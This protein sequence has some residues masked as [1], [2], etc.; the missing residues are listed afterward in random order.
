M[1]IRFCI[2]SLVLLGAVSNAAMAISGNEQV[3]LA[4]SGR[5]EE[6]W[7]RI[8]QDIKPDAMKVGDLHALCF[9]YSKTKRYNKLLP[10]LEQLEIK[11]QKGSKR[12]RLFGLD[13]ATPTVY[14]MR[15]EALLELGQYAQAIV[16]AD[17]ALAWFKREKSDDKDIEI[18]AYSI[19]AIA[20]VLRSDRAAA[21]KYAAQL[22]QV[23]T[24][25]PLYS[26]FKSIKAIAIARTGLALGRWQRTYDAISSDKTFELHAFLDKLVSGAFL[27]GRNNW[28][29]QELPRAFMLNK[30]LFGLGRLAEAKIGYE[31]LIKTP[32]VKENGEIYW[33]LLYDRGQIAEAESKPDEAIPFYQRAIEVIE[34]Q[35]STIHTEASKIGFV[36]DKQQ[37]Y[38]RIVHALFQ[39][40]KQAE[41]LE[42]IERSKSRALVDLLAAKQ[43]FVLPKAAGNRAAQLLKEYEL[44]EAE[45][46]AQ[47]PVSAT[48]GKSQQRNLAVQAVRQIGTVAPELSTL[49]SVTSLP[50]QELQSL[51]PQD[52]ALIQ[53][54]YHG[55]EFY[56]FILTRTSLQT[57]MLELS[58]LE[59]DVRRFREAIDRREDQALV[60]A[61]SL[62]RRLI[63]PIATG[64][65]HKNLL[66]IPHGVLHYLPFSALHD[67]TNYLIDR[68]APRVLP[69]ASVLKYL[70]APSGAKLDSILVFGNPDLGDSRLDLPNAQLEAE[71]VA[72]RAAQSKLLL[73]KQASETAFRLLSSE[74]PYIHFASHGQFDPAAPLNSALLL[75]KDDSNDGMLT[76]NELYSIPLDADLVTLSACETGLGK[77]S[78]GDDVV[79]L[80]RGFLYAGASSVIA[81]LWQVDDAAT[82]QLMTRFYANLQ[83]A[84]KREALRDALLET[85]KKFPHP[86]F[87]AAFYLTGNAH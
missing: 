55:K 23:D 48:E 66:I 35:R 81:S 78:N 7:Q 64:L 26:D 69:S 24:S 15:G 17:R 14:L 54:Y 63:L 67:G 68:Y 41:A 72:K 79:G 16:D 75:A 56:V 45:T 36:G 37:V 70:K 28:A 1:T 42:Y 77:I 60:L 6:L 29:W 57:S 34:S 32:Q 53:Y 65:P 43:G 3:E 62:Y 83:N 51:I 19:Q 52:E 85:K 61:Q 59:D 27:T 58:G 4:G 39:V 2:A 13:D 5:Y 21:E 86:Y 31:Q 18:N 76:V 40:Q 10:C 74:Y 20:S 73:R 38:G 80:T 8:E 33:L 44:A 47:P 49:I 50:L 30:A 9:A 12:T 71:D 84:N 25:W 82:S 46:I 87:W 11:L 22:E